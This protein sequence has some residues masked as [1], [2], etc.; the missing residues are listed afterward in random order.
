MVG[1]PE[2][3]EVAPVGGPGALDET[4]DP[5]A[6][7][8]EI[9]DADADALDRS[10]S[11]FRA[12]EAPERRRPGDRAQAV[13]PIALVRAFLDVHADR[14]RGGAVVADLGFGQT[15]ATEGGIQGATLTH[16]LNAME[17]TG[18]ITRR[19]DPDNRRVHVVELTDEGETVFH[20]LATAAIAHDK[21]IRAG[22][23]DE[24]ITNWPVC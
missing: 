9:G 24:E 7:P 11:A 2:G 21:R 18:L 1:D 4:V 12:F 16:H 8:G 17:N 15:L 20:R 10:F 13:D 19:R 14:H 22:L 23:S 3:V 5:P 6:R